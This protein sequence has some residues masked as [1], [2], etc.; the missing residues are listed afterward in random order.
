MTTVPIFHEINRVVLEQHKFARKL[1][2]DNA[3]PEPNIIWHYT[4]ADG[5]LGILKN[6]E[7]FMSHILCMNDTEEFQHGIS[8]IIQAVGIRGRSSV[9][10]SASKFHEALTPSLCEYLVVP[11]VPDIFVSCFSGETDTLTHWLEYGRNGVG[12]AVGFD[13][14]RLKEI[15]ASHCAFLPCVYDD[16]LKEKIALETHH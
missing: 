11:N 14:A 7:L 3:A 13:T 5:L 12:Y 8:H 4:T 1:I 15:S 9:S 6:Q 2:K 10:A 16:E